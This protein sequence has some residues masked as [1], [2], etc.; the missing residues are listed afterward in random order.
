VKQQLAAIWMMFDWLVI[1]QIVPNN[2]A[3][4]VRGPKQ[5]AVIKVCCGLI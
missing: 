5:G 4:A 2:P 3:S 1:G